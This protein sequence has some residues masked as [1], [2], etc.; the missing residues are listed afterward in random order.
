M[1][2]VFQPDEE[3]GTGAR[4]LIADG[5]FERFGTPAVVLGQHVAPLP[6]GVLGVT[7]G[8]A[9]A[10]TDMI[11]VVL[12]GEGGHGSRPESAVDP[13]V[14]GASLVLRLQ[15]VVSREVGGS[16]M[17]VLTVGTF[18]A[19]TRGNIIPDRAV[20]E[21]S[22]RTTDPAVRDKAVAAIE[23]MAKAEALAA[24]APRE[25]EVEVLFSLPAVVNDAGACEQV[26]AAFA[27]TGRFL[28]VDPGAVTGSED[29]GILSDT[30]GVPGAYWLLGGA[31]PA[32]FAGAT[33]VEEPDRPGG[34]AA[35]QPLAVLRPGGA[36]DPGVGRGGAGQRRPRLPGLS[37]TRPSA[38]SSASRRT[39]RAR[40]C[41]RP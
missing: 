23:R 6:A 29:V 14:M 41:R 22:L 9:F 15:T 3:G 12:H 38:R 4:S 37:L 21:I 18:H 31:D 35:G 28:V 10:A 39:C 30:A 5:L 24:G 13:V 19:G 36:P 17:V 20:L 11:R 2:L 7:P 40:R 33:T 34:G 26:A 25:P 32:T 1:V 16:D 27:A 8:P